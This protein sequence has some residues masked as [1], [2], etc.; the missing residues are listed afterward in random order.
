MQLVTFKNF[1]LATWPS[2]KEAKPFPESDAVS[3]AQLSF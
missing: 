2:Q 1:D 3:D